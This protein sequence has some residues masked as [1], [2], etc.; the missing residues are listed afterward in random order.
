MIQWLHKYI[1]R[2][3]IKMIVPIKTANL[4]A[5]FSCPKWNPYPILRRLCRYTF[6]GLASID[7]FFW[8]LGHPDAS[9]T[10][11]RLFRLTGRWEE[12]EGALV[13]DPANFVL[14]YA[15]S[16]CAWC[17][18]WL[19]GHWPTKPIIPKSAA[20]AKEISQRERPHDAKYWLEF[21]EAQDCFIEVVDQPGKTMTTQDHYIGID[22]NYGEYGLVVWFEKA[23]YNLNSPNLIDTVLV[24]TYEHKQYLRKE[25]LLADFTWV[26]V[27]K[28]AV[29][30]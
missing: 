11:P 9:G 25:V 7:H 30:P 2:G 17:I 4:L 5:K 21:L 27:G 24:S 22:P 13:V 26:K 28:K 29:R 23:Y 14:R 3:I 12:D 18:R 16:Y 6:W 10:Y 1:T 20:H 15:T 19:T 8:S